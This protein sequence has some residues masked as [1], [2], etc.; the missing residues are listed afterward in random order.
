MIIPGIYFKK[1]TRTGE[2]NEHAIKSVINEVLDK[3]FLQSLQKNTVSNQ[4]LFQVV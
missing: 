4:Q 2:V 3:T 1:G